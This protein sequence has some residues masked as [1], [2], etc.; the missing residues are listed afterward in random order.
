MIEDGLVDEVKHLVAMGYDLKLKSLGSVGYRHVCLFL[1][2]AMPLHDAMTLMKRDTRRLAKR[3]LTW[4]RRD[5]EVRWRH[6]DRER[7]RIM[8]LAKEFIG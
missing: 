5:G 4:F 8:Q 7:A 3:Q 1:S 6:P 2:G